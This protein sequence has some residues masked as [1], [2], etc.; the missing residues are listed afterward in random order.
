MKKIFS[1]LSF[2][3]VMSMM[4]V[5]VSA[6]SGINSFEQSVLDNYKAGVTV[7]GKLVVPT[8]GEITTATNL[9]NHDD[10]D[11]TEY[12]AGRVNG[13]IDEIYALFVKEGV[14]QVTALSQAS[15]EKALSLATSAALSV[16]LTFTYDPASNVAAVWGAGGVI[17]SSDVT[18]TSSMVK[19]TGIEFNFSLVL[20][21]MMIMSLAGVGVVALKK[22]NA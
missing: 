12:Q 13:A 8:A 10:V 19:Q 1:L 9:L 16:G 22:E 3:L 5:G 20:G 18:S 21:M 7:N 17:A 14:T 11:M 4:F 2:V 6:A 15:K